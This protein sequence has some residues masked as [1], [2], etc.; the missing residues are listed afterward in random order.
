MVKLTGNREWQGKM[1]S[2]TEKERKKQIAY[3]RAA[4]RELGQVS[5]RGT[6]TPP[7]GH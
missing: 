5:L 3:H 6:N 2:M 1:P 4:L 7:T